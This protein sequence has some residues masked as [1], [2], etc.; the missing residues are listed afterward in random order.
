MTLLKWL[1]GNSDR[2]PPCE[3]HEL[4]E[5]L[6]RADDR[7]WW[8]DL[9][10]EQLQRLERILEM[11]RTTQQA[12]LA[13]ERRIAPDAARV[14]LFQMFPTFYTTAAER[15]AQECAPEDAPLPALLRKRVTDF[16][17]RVSGNSRVLFQASS[18]NALVREAA[19]RSEL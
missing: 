10:A 12:V 3:V 2:V 19:R 13:N 18:F 6:V 5:W 8:R 7:E 17:G 1:F 15:E 16:A 4:D 11:F 14:L 9:S